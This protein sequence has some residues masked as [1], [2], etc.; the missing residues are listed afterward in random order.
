MA[1]IYIIYTSIVE[2][3]LSAGGEYYTHIWGRKHDFSYNSWSNPIDLTSDFDLTECIFPSM[4][5]TMNNQL[6]IVAQLDAEPG[7]SVPLNGDS[8]GTNSMIYFTIDKSDFV[9]NYNNVSGIVFDDVNENGVRD[10]LEQAVVGNIIKIEPGPFYTV[11]NTFG[12]Y[13]FE[14]APGNHTITCIPKQ[15][16]HMTNTYTSYNINVIDTH[17]LIDTL[18]FSVTVDTNVKDLSISITGTF[19]RPGFDANYWINYFNRGFV[20]LSG[21]VFD[22]YPPILNYINSTPHENAHISNILEYNFSSL[23]LDEQRMISS[24]FLVPVNATIGDTI[25]SYIRIEPLVGDTNVTNNYDTLMQVITGSY[26]P[27]D[28]SVIPKGIGE[29]G[30]I[31]HGKKTHLYHPFSKYRN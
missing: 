18:D 22:K 19:V 29:E 21:T 16:W 8:P 5:K 2:D 28:K 6:H 25:Y 11:S 26:D 31:L 14:A 27:N 24:T 30:Y 12:E 13:Q 3:M 4:S 20:T 1:T 10:V 15:Y 23:Y 7:L 9:C 17:I